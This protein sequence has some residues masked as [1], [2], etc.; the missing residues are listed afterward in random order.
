MSAETRVQIT[1]EERRRI[2]DSMSPEERRQ[3]SEESR[4]RAMQQIMFGITDD[5]FHREKEQ[6]FEAR[7]EQIEKRLD[8]LELKK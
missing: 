5:A 2:R 3:L 1:D 4:D 7:L 6:Q 8:V